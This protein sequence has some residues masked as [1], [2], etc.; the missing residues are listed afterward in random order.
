MTYLSCFAGFRFVPSCRAARNL[1]STVTQM[2]IVN[3]R[4]R[5]LLTWQRGVFRGSEDPTLNT[6]LRQLRLFARAVAL[7]FRA[8]KAALMSVPGLDWNKPEIPV[9][10]YWY[11]LALLNVVKVAK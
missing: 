10:R 3:T 8:W 11:L 1:T 7:S 9:S 5:I 2:I 4:R 6:L